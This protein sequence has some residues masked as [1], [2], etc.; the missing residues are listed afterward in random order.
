MIVKS[1]KRQG[2]RVLGRWGCRAAAPLQY[3]A[4]SGRRG[5]S[6]VSMWLTGQCGST[7]GL[8]LASPAQGCPG[9][10]RGLGIGRRRRPG[11]GRVGGRAVWR[12]RSWPSTCRVWFGA[13]RAAGGHFGMRR[14]AV[15]GLAGSGG[16]HAVVT[17]GAKH[18]GTQADTL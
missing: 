14:F 5:K 9:R 10:R 15:G 1:P 7:V 3:L 6:A 18:G 16:C 12:G 13:N 8:W 2:M 4:V 17:S 11:I